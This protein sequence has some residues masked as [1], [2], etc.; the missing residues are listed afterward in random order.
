MG[1]SS[2]RSPACRGCSAMPRR[3]KCVVRIWLGLRLRHTITGATLAWRRFGLAPGVAAP[4]PVRSKRRRRC[5][6]SSHVMTSLFAGGSLDLTSADIHWH[7][8]ENQCRSLFLLS[9]RGAM[10]SLRLLS[11]SVSSRPV[12]ACASARMPSLPSSS[13]PTASP[14]LAAVVHHGGAG[15]TAAG[16]RAGVPAVIIPFFADQ[17]FWAER[18]A[19]LGGG[20][21]PIPRRRLTAERMAQAITQ[22]TAPEMRARAAEIGRQIAAEHGVARAVAYIEQALRIA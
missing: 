9:A 7:P 6:L 1:G 11:E 14:W 17:P 18:V 21:A 2:A 8:K 15:T 19:A 4:L 12:I 16:L 13:R 5:P 20:P 3:W 10:S 22:A